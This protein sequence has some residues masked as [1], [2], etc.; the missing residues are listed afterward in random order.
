M[1]VNENGAKQKQETVSNRSFT[2]LEP[3]HHFVITWDRGEFSAYTNLVPVSQSVT[4]LLYNYRLPQTK[5]NIIVYNC[6]V[7]RYAIEIL[8]YFQCLVLWSSLNVVG[9]VLHPRLASNC[10]QYIDHKLFLVQPEIWYLL[11]E[12][13]TNAL[14]SKCFHW[15]LYTDALAFCVAGCN[16]VNSERIVMCELIV[17]FCYLLLVCFMSLLSLERKGSWNERGIKVAN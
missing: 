14:M 1:F 9:C 16:T 13:E 7:N 5:I 17:A 10:Q 12:R 3:H 4:H 15:V 11:P 6:I 8:K 2:I